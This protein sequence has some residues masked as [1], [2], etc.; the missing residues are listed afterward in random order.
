MIKSFKFP[1]S[2]IRKFHS[3]IS[4]I[5][6]NNQEIFSE[7]PQK[8]QDQVHK[9]DIVEYPE[10]IRDLNTDLDWK[11]VFQKLST[12]DVKLIPDEIK[13]NL[14]LKV[15]ILSYNPDVLTKLVQEFNINIDSPSNKTR[16]TMLYDACVNSHPRIVKKILDLGANPEVKVFAGKTPYHAAAV[17]SMIDEDTG[18]EIFRLLCDKL[19]PTQENIEKI[20][21]IFTGATKSVENNAKIIIGN[22]KWDLT[23]SKI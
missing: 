7:F 19:P 23:C 22:E 6:K 17:R 20:I 3:S 18:I 21:G 1:I 12:V 8:N 14:L 15:A 10:N 2:S 4:L 13:Y 11:N 9:K 16:H 5:I